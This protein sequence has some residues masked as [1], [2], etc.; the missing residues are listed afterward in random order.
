LLVDAINGPLLVRFLAITVHLL[1]MEEKAH[2][3]HSPP[4][5]AFYRNART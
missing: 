3:D 2:A 1:T 4:Q 5:R